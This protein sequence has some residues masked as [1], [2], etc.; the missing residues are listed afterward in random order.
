[1]EGSYAKTCCE[2]SKEEGD[3]T[4]MGTQI[5]TDSVSHSSGVRLKKGKRYFRRWA[6]GAQSVTV[7]KAVNSGNVFCVN[8]MS[9]DGIRYLGNFEKK[10][11]ALECAMGVW[12]KLVAERDV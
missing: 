10:S 7:F 12:S 4:S 6:R 11:Q 3:A 9:K 1:M 5:F 2:K 8:I